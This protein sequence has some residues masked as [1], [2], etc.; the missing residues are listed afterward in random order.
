MSGKAAPGQENQDAFSFGKNWAAFIER[1]FSE[2]RVRI[3][4][5]QLL[6]FLELPDL[7][8]RSFLDIGCGSGLSS[9]AA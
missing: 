2:E 4:R 1:H 5:Q 8:G 7:A 3:A 9:L 6:A